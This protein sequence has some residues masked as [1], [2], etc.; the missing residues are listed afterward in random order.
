MIPSVARPATMGAHRPATGQ[1]I[2]VST[3]KRQFHTSPTHF[4]TSDDDMEEVEIIPAASSYD[5]FYIIAWSHSYTHHFL[6]SR[7]RPQSSAGTQYFTNG[8]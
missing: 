5:C 3:P 4:Q 7:V 1:N 8:R 6:S 2:L